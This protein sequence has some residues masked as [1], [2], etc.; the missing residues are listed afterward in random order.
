MTDIKSPLYNRTV[1]C[2]ACGTKTSQA[3]FKAGMYV[4][5]ER[6]ADQHVTRYRYLQPDVTPVHP[7][8]YALAHC[9]ECAFADFKEDFIDPTRT[10]EN[11]VHLLGSRLRAERGRAGSVIRMLHQELR[12]G[13][14]D[15][16]MALRLH[17]LAIAIQELLPQDRRD[18]LKIARLYL[19]T[20]WLYREQG[21]T[22]Q[23]SVVKSEGLAALGQCAALLRDLR[24]AADRLVTVYAG[25]SEAPHAVA[26]AKQLEDLGRSF[27]DLR[28]HLVGQGGAGNPLGFLT[29]LRSEW[30]GLPINETVC[31]QA[32]L[33]AFEMEYQQGEGDTLALLKLMIEINCRLGQFDRVLEYTS[34]ISKSGHEE[35]AKLQRQLAADRSL[36]GEERNRL[37]VRINRINASLQLAS[38]IH[39]DI[40]SRQAVASAA[41]A[42]SPS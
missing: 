40:L 20:A 5:E 12:P 1:P 26:F 13:P 18:H 16:P 35:R 15:F 6:E 3:E 33:R 11:R 10:R 41:L 21:D 42:T 14:M 32:S 25:E 23:P 29:R 38:E 34:S 24:A 37:V 2:P 19:R 27:A 31:L 17:L 36:S 9:P 28:G 4:E 22:A 7:P 39:Q 30:P 8:F